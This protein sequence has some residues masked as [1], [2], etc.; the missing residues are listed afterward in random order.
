MSQ[1]D[2]N[3]KLTN[4]LIR[5]S[6]AMTMALTV[7]TFFGQDQKDSLVVYCLS[8]KVLTRSRMRP[9]QLKDGPFRVSNIAPV[10][11]DVRSLYDAIRL[12]DR[13]PIKEGV[14]QHDFRL[15][16]SIAKDD[17]CFS[18]DATVAYVNGSSFSLSESETNLVL[19]LFRKLD[20]L[21][22]SC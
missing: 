9:Q 18:S 21:V 11:S 19:T 16:I 20:S 3:A 10:A 14:W 15:C 17:K 13:K 8:P 22:Y 2:R 12:T 5:L 4:L 6:A 1:I 7:G